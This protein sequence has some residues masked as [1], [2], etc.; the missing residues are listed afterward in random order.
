MS[1]RTRAFC[2]AIAVLLLIPSQKGSAQQFAIKSNV[3]YDALATPDIGFEVVTGN[4]TSLALSIFGNWQPYGLSTKMLVI[5]PEFRYWFNGRP[6]TREYI[7]VAGFVTAYDVTIA[8]AVHQG[9]GL[10]LGLSG[11]Y[12]FSLGKRWNLDLSAGTGVLLFREKQY[13]ETDHFDDYYVG[14]WSSTNTWGY[15]LFPVKLAV[16][17][18]YIIK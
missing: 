12:V 6:L 15:K 5:Q 8:G 7:G 9:D 1:G 14:S 3:L 10:A 16:T 11:G 18:I 4:H 13:V 2:I 17:F